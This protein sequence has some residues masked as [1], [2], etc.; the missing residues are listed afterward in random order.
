MLIMKRREGEAIL[1]G[2][3]IEVQL[4]Y[5]GRKKVKI[6]I[7]AP[8]HLRVIAKEIQNVRDENQA[9]SGIAAGTDLATVISRV[10]STRQRSQGAPFRTV[11]GG[12]TIPDTGPTPSARP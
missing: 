6:A 10:E 1:I 2:D 7:R 3:E 4:I 11:E 5:I 9:A 12:A 8:R